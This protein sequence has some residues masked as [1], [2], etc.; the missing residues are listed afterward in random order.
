MDSVSFRPQ[1]FADGLGFVS[2]AGRLTPAYIARA[3]SYI[4]R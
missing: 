3:Y 1:R 2:L 4:V